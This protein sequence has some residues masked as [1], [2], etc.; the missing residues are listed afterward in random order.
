M[1]AIRRTWR[2]VWDLLVG[3]AA[4]VLAFGAVPGVLAGFVGTPVPSHWS[5]RDVLSLHG[6]F[7]LLALAAWVAWAAC[8]W[9]LLRSVVI[10]VRARDALADGAPAG[11]LWGDRLALR[12]A[13]AVLAMAP[14]SAAG[15]VT[16]GAA[17][18]RGPVRPPAAMQ[19]ADGAV[20]GTG[21][22]TGT[23]TGELIS[24]VT[25]AGDHSIT[26]GDGDSLSRLAETAY[27]D[28]GAWQAIATVNLGRLMSDGRRFVD[29]NVVQPGWTLSVPRLDSSTLSRSPH[30]TPQHDSERPDRPAP[31]S[32]FGLLLPELA[33][34]GT[35]TIVAGLL[36]RRSRRMQR[37]RA[38]VRQEGAGS[39]EPSTAAAD[40]G[41]VLSGFENVPVLQNVE[42]AVRM[43]GS[44]ADA[45]GD[46]STLPPVQLVR[47]GSDGVEV[48]FAAPPS[49]A[50]TPWVP[51][52]PRAW[53]LPASVEHD[54]LRDEAR[55]HRPWTPILLPLGEDERGSWLLPLTAGARVS[56]I[57]PAAR[58]LAH[59]MV[60]GAEGWTWHEDLLVTN[61]PG[62]VAEATG[63]LD[64]R[65]DGSMY[66]RVLFTGDPDALP[67]QARQRCAVLAFGVVEAADVSVFADARAATVHPLGLTV[68][69][70]LLDGSWSSAIAELGTFEAGYRISG[71]RS[72]MPNGRRPGGRT[73]PSGGVDRSA[74]RP[75]GDADGPVGGITPPAPAFRRRHPGAATVRVLSEARPSADPALGLV[76][77]GR[78]GAIDVRLL[79]SVPV[80]HGLPAELAPKRA[81][82]ATEIVA[83]LA[84]H[85]PNPVTGDR[86][87]TRVLGT[88]DADAASKTLFN[89]VG[90]ARRALGVGVDGQPLLP[91]ANRSGHY[92]LSAAVTVDARRCVAL[93]EAGRVA[94]DHGERV[95]LLQ[96]GLSHL[97]GEPLSG[98]LTGFGWWRPEGHERRV[99]D[100]VVDGT[101][102]LV[103]I[104]VETRQ[105]DLGR[106]ALE[107]A[108]LVE[109]Y[110]E[111]LTRAAMALAAAA[112]DARRLRREW[113][114]C[115]RQVDELD[116]GGMPS[117][118]TERLYVRLRQHVQR[119]APADEPTAVLRV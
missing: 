72:D 25:P 87:R 46:T 48:R 84:M 97:E 66:P 38:F 62:A 75:K 110:S 12:I 85:A 6:L 77:P 107:R 10:R 57:G 44:S 95:A 106:W 90:A 9:P 99:A 116:P 93:L 35:G 114:E 91:P 94:P 80:I 19:P 68:R 5:R 60:A 20:L 113:D 21:T 63:T 73:T 41:R 76:E 111:V 96:A 13:A 65:P 58:P 51:G 67:M 45:V 78:A 100:A 115:K 17:V 7:D 4:A 89:T 83:Y 3:V 112:G 30:D 36:A 33:I 103:R 79:T 81:R 14:V 32:P 74:D 24:T 16:G 28:G 54:D 105:L 49:P 70:H 86:L 64:K 31:R 88:A 47:A 11:L 26:V 39:S 61:D 37:L 34:L 92:S 53:I 109:P 69:P 27:G 8:A 104:A 119:G 102:A 59:A 22:G 98:V 2:A 23:G 40:L 82:R 18:S 117:E 42:L 108:R 50:R 56:M 71:R 43:I 118:A 101:S 15:A 29:P 1:P 55:R 52:G